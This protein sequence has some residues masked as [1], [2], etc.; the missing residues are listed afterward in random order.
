MT[1]AQN[2]ANPMLPANPRCSTAFCIAPSLR[3]QCDRQIPATHLNILQRQKEEGDPFRLVRRSRFGPPHEVPQY[4][5]SAVH[6][7]RLLQIGRA[8]HGQR[9][10][11]CGAGSAAQ[12]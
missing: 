5:C 3:I 6:L 8:G 7:P 11:A 1:E 12:G 4:T 2:N 9:N 10:R